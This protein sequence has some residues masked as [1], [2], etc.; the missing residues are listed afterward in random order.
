MPGGEL[1]AAVRLAWERAF[2]DWPGR[3]PWGSLGLLAWVLTVE[4][5]LSDRRLDLTPEQVWGWGRAGWAAREQAHGYPI[6]CF[7]DSLMRG[8]IMPRVIEHRTGKA[9]YNL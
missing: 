2:G 9:A 3:L 6:L 5:W 1:R 8:G 4:V 7:G